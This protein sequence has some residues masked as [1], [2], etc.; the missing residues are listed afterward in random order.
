[1]SQVIV[2]QSRG[3][4]ADKPRREMRR[5]VHVKF[6]EGAKQTVIAGTLLRASNA[7]PS[8]A[9]ELLAYESDVPRIQALVETDLAGLRRAQEAHERDLRKHLAEKTGT[10]L[11]DVSAD[12]ATWDENMRRVESTYGGSS[13]EAKFHDMTGRGIK[14]LVEVV[15]EDEQLDP[16]LGE[17]EESVAAVARQFGN[18]GMNAGDLAQALVNAMQVAGVIASPDD[19]SKRSK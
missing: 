4:Q 7:G 6:R 18:G 2:N 11:D 17:H 19:R 12:P 13:P 10:P 1:M 8:G 15:V 9:V 14:P 16:P 5:R 3:P